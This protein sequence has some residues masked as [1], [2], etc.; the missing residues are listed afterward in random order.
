MAGFNRYKDVIDTY[1]ETGAYWFNGFRKAHAITT[2]QGNWFDMSMTSGNPKP[3]YYTG[4]ELRATSLSWQNGIFHGPKTSDGFKYIHKFMIVSQQAGVAPATF[5]LCDYLMYYPLI[6]MDNTDEQL[7]IN[8]GVD[9]TTTTHP[10]AVTLPRY[11]DGKGV[12]MFLVAT[13]PYVGGAVFQINYTNN[14]GTAGR[15]T[16]PITSNINTNIQTII[17]SGATTYLNSYGAFIPLAFGDGGVRSVESIT[18]MAGNG[19]LAALV[20][21][22]PIATIMLRET[23]ACSETDFMLDLPSLPKIYDTA[24]LNMLCLPYG[25]AAASVILGSIETIWN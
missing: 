3:N 4:T 1:Y 17:S 20:L 24:Y 19:G 5:L 14:L 16:I 8:Y 7:F 11:T 10:L 23:T 18:F 15:I 9:I 6:D 25:T 12:Q 13:N 22:K 2:V 21:C